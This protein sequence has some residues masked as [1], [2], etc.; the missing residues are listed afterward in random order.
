LGDQGDFSNKITYAVPTPIE[1]SFNLPFD[2][3]T[4][5]EI[6]SANKDAEFG[7]LCLSRDGLM[8]IDFKYDDSLRVTYFMVRKQEN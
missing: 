3:N 1:S 2:A 4:F 7:K 5:K 6:L 8:K